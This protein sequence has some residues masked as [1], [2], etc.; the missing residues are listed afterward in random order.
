MDKK[1]IEK[2]VVKHDN[3]ISPLLHS[4][5]TNEISTHIK[6][7]EDLI[8]AQGG[9][10]FAKIYKRDVFKLLGRGKQK[11]DLLMWP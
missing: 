9:E 2:A 8:E 7:V 3:L 4:V 10:K 1:A 11:Q 5:I 6:A